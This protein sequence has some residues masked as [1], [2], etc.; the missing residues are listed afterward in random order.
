MH[1]YF[2]Q[3]KT[4]QYSHNR[5]REVDPHTLVDK[6]HASFSCRH[7]DQGPYP[8]HTELVFHKKI[9]FDDVRMRATI[10]TRWLNQ[11]IRWVPWFRQWTM[12]PA[13]QTVLNIP[14]HGED[15]AGTYV[16]FLPD[17]W[18]NSSTYFFLSRRILSFSICEG[19]GR[20][21]SLVYLSL[22]LD[23]RSPSKWREMFCLP[24]SLWMVGQTEIFNVR[25]VSASL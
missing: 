21:R 13:K 18:A 15:Q 10:Q 20:I 2:V 4:L 14:H 11:S 22:S 6:N 25:R 8:C 12:R 24:P 19:R 1:K 9:D 16:F 3:L 5:I 17:S 7:T 23:I